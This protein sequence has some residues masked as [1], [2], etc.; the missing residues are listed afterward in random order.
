MVARML[1]PHRG[2][3]RHRLLLR[4]QRSLTAVVARGPQGGGERGHW[5]TTTKVPHAE[6]WLFNVKSQRTFA[7]DAISRQTAGRCLCHAKR[8]GYPG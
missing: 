2:R 3:G 4:P 7:L 5:P 8:L 6:Q 1:F